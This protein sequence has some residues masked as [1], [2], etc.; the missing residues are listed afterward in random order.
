MPK[1]KNIGFLSTTLLLWAVI[2]IPSSLFAGATQSSDFM[3]EN[4]NLQQYIH[5]EPH[6]NIYLGAGL[7]PVGLMKNRFFFGASIFQAHYINKW[8]DV[9]MLNI[10]FGASRAEES[11]Y[12][13]Y[14]FI[15]RASPKYRLFDFLSIGP[16]VALEYVSFPDVS[17]KEYKIP[18]FTPLEPFSSLGYIWGVMISEQFLYKKYIIKINQ[19]FYQQN[20]SVKE[21]LHGWSYWFEDEELQNDPEPI[22]AGFIIG[23][24]LSFL[25]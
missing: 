11:E 9:E 3:K 22:E 18:Y 13:A 5:K 16:L 23:L 7:V 15:F 24:E 20:Y 25:F 4:K 8:V 14:H 17:K 2:F 19:F 12:S 1:I 10:T 21:S 6:S